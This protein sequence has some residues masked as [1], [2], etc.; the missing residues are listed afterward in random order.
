MPEVRA[1]AAARIREFPRP[2]PAGFATFLG[3]RAVKLSG[4]IATASP[5]RA[6]CAP[7]DPPAR[8]G[9]QRARR[10]LGFPSP[11]SVSRRCRRLT[12]LV[13]AIALRT[14]LKADRIIVID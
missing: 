11:A 4:A 2:L 10:R 6:S 3:E 1:A 13:I 14:V 5:P 9:D 12:N 7:C 8:R